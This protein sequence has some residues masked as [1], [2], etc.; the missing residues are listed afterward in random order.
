MRMKWEYNLSR[1]DAL[2]HV[3]GNYFDNN[4]EI[5][6]YDL[7]NDIEKYIKKTHIKPKHIK[8]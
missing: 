1:R 2:I 6:V 3:I 4:K 5:S 8:R 7:A